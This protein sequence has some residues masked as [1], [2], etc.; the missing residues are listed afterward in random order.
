MATATGTLKNVTQSEH[1]AEVDSQDSQKESTEPYT[2]QPNTQ[3]PSPQQP[4]PQ[5]AAAAAG[6]VVL[7]RTQVLHEEMV[8]F[9]ATGNRAR[10]EFLQR[11]AE[12]VR[13]RHYLEL[14]LPSAL[15]Y[16]QCVL[17]V[18]RSTAY[19]SLSLCRELEKLPLLVEAFGHGKF[20][21]RV[22]RELLLVAIPE[23]E[24]E[25]LALATDLQRTGDDVIAEAKDARRN[26]RRRPR[27]ESHGLPNLPTRVTLEMTREQWELVHTALARFGECCALPRAEVAEED[28]EGCSDASDVSGENPAEAIARNR[29]HS[30]P[31]PRLSL[32]EG[33]IGLSQWIIDRGDHLSA[34]PSELSP[35]QRDP[36]SATPARSATKIVYHHCP[37]CRKSAVEALEGSVEVDPDSV[38]RRADSAEVVTISPEEELALEALPDGELD[39]PNSSR[40]A[41]RVK[42]R[43]GDRCR[44]PACRRRGVEL[45]AH[46]FRFRA[47]GGRT[48]LANEVSVCGTCHAL[49]HAG[50]LVVEGTPGEK[51]RWIPRVGSMEWRSV[52]FAMPGDGAGWG[53]GADVTDATS[54]ATDRDEAQRFRR[55]DSEE[56]RGAG[57]GAR[58][59]VRHRGLADRF[60]RADSELPSSEY[61]APVDPVGA[62]TLAMTSE[63][64][65]AMRRRSEFDTARAVVESIVGDSVWARALTERAIR[66]L[67][68]SGGPLEAGKIAGLALRSRKEWG[69]ELE[70]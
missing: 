28:A 17:K 8:R 16:L 63:I 65:L 39:V 30:D 14:G 64:T 70:R 12:F 69:R 59:P 62:V 1:P 7:P 67:E 50:L 6:C 27:Q 2:Q 54:E 20:S 31:L 68:T 19:E 9:V 43:D 53:A 40:L 36:A 33:L 10:I 4:S 26:G 46:H 37:S 51:L 34:G 22:L 48:C 29:A 58:S 61:A 60:R 15:A 35:T 13:D 23:T 42:S 66:E 21:Y 24:E 5:A 3:Q 38:V 44:N 32:E 56:V 11:L 45:H 18:P 41:S 55:A 49:I 25:W 52:F 57:D 47:A